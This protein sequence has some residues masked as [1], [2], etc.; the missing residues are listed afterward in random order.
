MDSPRITHR[1]IALALIGT[2]AAALV[3]GGFGACVSGVEPISGQLVRNSLHPTCPGCVHHEDCCS[4]MQSHQQ[5]SP[6]ESIP[7]CDVPCSVSIP[8][9]P[10]SVEKNSPWKDGR[11]PALALSSGQSKPTGMRGIASDTPPLT[12]LLASTDTI[13]SVVLLF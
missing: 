2:I 4:H 10:N 3:L 1:N 8:G 7:C 13:R 12:N 5:F 9:I 11:A 6:K